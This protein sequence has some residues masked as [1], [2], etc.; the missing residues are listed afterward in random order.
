MGSSRT[1]TILGL[2]LLFSFS[3]LAGCG[4][5][6]NTLFIASGPGFQFDPSTVSW[7]IPAGTLST[8][9][10]RTIRAEFFNHSPTQQHRWVLIAGGDSEAAQVVAAAA[11]Q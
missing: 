11:T 2:M 9:F 4:E 1:F 3:V 6:V 7:K 10:S 8:V 5:Q